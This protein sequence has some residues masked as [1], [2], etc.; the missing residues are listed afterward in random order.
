MKTI[1]KAL[2]RILC[3]T[4]ALLL[5]ASLLPVLGPWLQGILPEGN[6][7]RTS[8]KLT[9]AMEEAGELTAITFTDTGVSVTETKALVVGTVLK[10]TVPYEYQIGFGF[11][12]SDVVLT[13]SDHSITVQLPEIRMLHD[14]FTVTG[15][16]Q[17]EK[18]LYDLTEKKYQQI[19]D[20]EAL[21]CR[22]QYLESHEYQQAAWDAACKSL[23]SLFTQWSGQEDLPLTFV[24]KG[25]AVAL[26]P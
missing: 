5:A 17:V 14:S 15:E 11:S 3:T 19:L 13:A 26:A 8:T 16:P 7:H 21:A 24:P 2:V 1:G 12:L 6:Y 23:T 9:H 20:E 25:E 18:F 10:V 22:N 4:V